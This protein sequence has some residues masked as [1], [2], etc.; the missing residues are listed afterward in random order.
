MSSVIGTINLINVLYGIISISYSQEHVMCL[1]HVEYQKFQILSPQLNVLLRITGYLAT[2]N[3]NYIIDRLVSSC[4][5]LHCIE[6]GNK[7]AMY[8]RN[9]AITCNMLHFMHLYKH[10][11]YY[12]CMKAQ[13]SMYCMLYAW[14]VGELSHI[15]FSLHVLGAQHVKCQGNCY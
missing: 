11:E 7:L 3:E 12:T 15:K 13:G 10:G 9:Y 1:A 14:D 5:I 2:H 6:L 4:S 8:S